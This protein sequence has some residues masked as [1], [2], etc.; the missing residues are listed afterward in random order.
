MKRS[1]VA[2]VLLMALTLTTLCSC[3]GTAQPPASTSK[4]AA[5][6][7]T[8]DPHAP[9][10]PADDTERTLLHIY[11]DGEALNQAGYSYSDIKGVVN[12]RQIDGAYYYGATVADITRTDLSDVKGAFLE[13]I[14][15][16]I[17]Y[18]E[19]TSEL[20]LAAY[21]FENGTYE[22][23]ELDG[24]VVYG[25]VAG[26]TYNKGVTNVYLVTAPAAFEVEIQRNG[27]KLGVLTLDDFMKKTM[28][29]DQKVSTGMFDGSFLYNYGQD[30]YVG[31]FLGIDYPTMLAKT[32]RPWYRH[33]RYH[34]RG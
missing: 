30:T 18:V 4:T 17:T 27:E 11:K 13:G 1:T 25:G 28:I 23:V 14:D 21:A 3:T 19:D 24:Q 2:M 8:A 6:Q 12:S 7:A 33:H 15:G 20:Y 31:S 34:P 16:Y 32:C 22:S 29:E 26:P 10:A 9:A 5:Q